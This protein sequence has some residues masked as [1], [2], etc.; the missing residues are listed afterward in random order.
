M[1]VLES[2]VLTTHC[3]RYSKSNVC[4]Y[5]PKF[6]TPEEY[7]AFFKQGLE[8]CYTHLVEPSTEV[9]AA[10]AKNTPDMALEKKHDMACKELDAIKN[11]LSWKITKPLR[12]VRT[13][14]N[15]VKK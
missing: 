7:Y 8:A 5:L 10:S 13:L 1:T 11:T 14:L 12:A 6:D 2:S 4:V 9:A 3:D 15:K